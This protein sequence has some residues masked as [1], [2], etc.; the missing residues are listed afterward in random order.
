MTTIREFVY[1]DDYPA[2]VNLWKTVGPGI[3]Y[4]ESDEPEEIQRKLQR[5][6]DLFLV[7]ESD[8]R[9]IG[10]IIGGYD[11]RRGMLY[12]LA[13]DSANRNQGIGSLLMSEVEKRLKGKG[14]IKCYL[15]V[16]SDNVDA[17]HLYENNDWIRM[18]KINIYTYR[19]ELK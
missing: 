7:A 8:G 17:M 10:T 2:A 6:P 15:M 14:C 12:H 16:A 1:P 13:V 4:G 9:I 19:K 3:H 5:D 11:G 18:D